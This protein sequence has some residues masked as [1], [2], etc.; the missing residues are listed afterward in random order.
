[1]LAAA[2]GC[3][4]SF[5]RPFWWHTFAELAGQEDNIFPRHERQEAR[6]D[7]GKAKNTKSSRNFPLLI[8][9]F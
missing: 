1:M 9:F 7:N 8:N 4:T 5:D 2:F 6:V 3:E